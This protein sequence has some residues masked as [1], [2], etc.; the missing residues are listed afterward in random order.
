MR[1]AIVG[2]GAV[3]SAL[4][5]GWVRAGHAVVFAVRD[6]AKA[7]TQ[8]LAARLGAG[9]VAMDGAAA[10]ADVVVLAVPW[11]AAEDALA[12]LGDLGG[13]PLIDATNPLQF[14]DGRLTLV[15]PDGRAGAEWVAEWAGT[16]R[17]VKTLNQVGAEMMS[18]Q[19]TMAAK[20]CLFLAG[21]DAA[22]NE[23]AATL[24]SDLGFEPLQAGG[25]DQARHLEHF[26][27]V[28]INQAVMRG[29]GRDWAF[30]ALRNGEAPA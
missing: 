20:P 14:A 15:Q 4:A 29:F 3:G 5:E 13:K 26:A 19:K 28:W 2:S 17:V 30:G 8:D 7:E 21:D 22:A 11:D 16:A 18:A 24:V 10:G 23:I 25:L 12:A 6:T 9:I 1:I 27:M